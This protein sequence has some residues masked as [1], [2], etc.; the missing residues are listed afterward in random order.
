MPLILIGQLILTPFAIFRCAYLL[1][2]NPE[3]ESVSWRN[4]TNKGALGISVIAGLCVCAY[5]VRAAVWHSAAHATGSIW[6][7]SALT[8]WGPWGV[9]LAFL[10]LI[11]SAAAKGRSQ[12][13]AAISCVLFATFWLMGFM[14]MELQ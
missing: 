2:K 4:K 8:N 5:A 12:I 7:S 3:V 13:A 14:L 10:G 6:V 11:F 9:A 1:A